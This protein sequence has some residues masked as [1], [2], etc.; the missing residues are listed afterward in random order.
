MRPLIDAPATSNVGC[1]LEV[2]CVDKIMIR[3]IRP[4]QHRKTLGV[5][6]PRERSGIDDCAA[7]RRTVPAHE[8]GERMDDNIRTILNG[9]QQDG[10]WYSVVY[11]QWNAVTVRYARQ[12]LDVRDVSRRIADAFAEDS[13]GVL[14]DQLLY[15]GRIIGVRKANCDTLIGQ[16]I[17][18]QCMCCAI[19]LWDR[20]DVTAQFRQVQHRIIDS[21]LP[22]GHT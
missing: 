22:R 10:C 3:R 12:R 15:C 21:S 6:F 5:F 7:E 14:I 1:V 18:E 13:T 16:N 9:P 2:I 11:Y 20:N 4:A 17:G 19:K 8:F